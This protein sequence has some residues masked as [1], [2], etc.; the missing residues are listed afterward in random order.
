MK[1]FFVQFLK[2]F[3]RQRYA[4]LDILESDKCLILAPHPDDESLG[5]GGLLIKYPK[6]CTVAF[7]TNGCIS[8]REF[9]PEENILIRRQEL[10]KAM[11]FVGIDKYE[12]LNIPDRQMRRNLSRLKSLNLKHYDYVF[13]P[14]KY[15]SHKDHKCLYRRVKRL[16]M[17]TKTRVAAY[18]V[19]STLPRVTHYLDISDCIGKK[20][21][22]IAIYQSQLKKT[23][24][25][26]GITAL[27]QYRGM[28]P[29]VKFAEGFYIGW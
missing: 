15:E 17:F 18:E 28:H 21:E 7:L 1:N 13:V 20:K 22:L 8:D 12:Y 5:C 16:L 26:G 3:K 11:N 9:T 25:I 6:Q 24:Y 23:D 14:N 29:K 10:E 27:N 2:I 4:P 19:W